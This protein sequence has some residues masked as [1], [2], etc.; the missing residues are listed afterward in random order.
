MHIFHLYKHKCVYS[1][2]RNSTLCQVLLDKL[3]IHFPLQGHLKIP[4]LYVKVYMQVFDTEEGFLN[5][6]HCK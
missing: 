5:K 3:N 2:N 4:Y 1:M 6:Q